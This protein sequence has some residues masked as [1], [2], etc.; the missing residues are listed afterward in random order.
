M[1]KNNLFIRAI[2]YVDKNPGLEWNEITGKDGL[3]LTQEENEILLNANK[4]VDKL[5][6]RQ[7]NDKGTP[8]HHLSVNSTFQLL[9]YEELKEAR[10]SA[11][12]ARTYAFIAI[13]I[14]VILAIVQMIISY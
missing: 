7:K 14:S 3:N 10:K 11:K 12:Q 4:K 8:G 5:F 6:I 1:D 13:G 2:K 9:E